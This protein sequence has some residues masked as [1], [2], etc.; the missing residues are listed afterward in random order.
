MHMKSVG[1]PRGRERRCFL[2]S[3]AIYEVTSAFVIPFLIATY[4]VMAISLTAVVITS[5]GNYRHLLGR[6]VVVGLGTRV[7]S[8]DHSYSV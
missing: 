1:L 7:E 5:G 6:K 3:I 2:I 4:H 8:L